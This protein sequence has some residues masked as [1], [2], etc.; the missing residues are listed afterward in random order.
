MAQHRYNLK[1]FRDG[2]SSVARNQYF[3]VDIGQT[4]GEGDT[5]TALARS[6][7]LPA[8]THGVLDVAFRGLNMRIADRPEFPEWTV[9]Y[10]CTEDHALRNAH[11]KWM[12]Q[13]YDVSDQV[14][15]AHRNYKRDETT[16][17]HLTSDHVDAFSYK[18]FGL[19]P[20]AVG[21]MALAQEG[22]EVMQFDVTYSYDN[23]LTAP[24]DGAKDLSGVLGNQDLSDGIE[25]LKDAYDSFKGKIKEV[26]DVVT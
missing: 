21:E 18:F 6:T 19:F 22:G 16:L 1:T 26:I 9:T 20:S 25:K 24:Q 23:F 4:I 3:Y 7:T 17:Y 11:I 15:K 14:N 10:L 13:A 5:L 8:I 12:H 2:L